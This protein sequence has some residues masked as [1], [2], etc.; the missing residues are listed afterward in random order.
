MSGLANSTNRISLGA[1][2]AFATGSDSLGR[3]VA[4][5]VPQLVYW[6]LLLVSKTGPELLSP[7]RAGT[8]VLFSLATRAAQN[9]TVWAETNLAAPNWTAQTSFAG[10]GATSQVTLPFPAAAARASYRVSQP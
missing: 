3:Y 2:L 8:N 5:T 9:Y 10:N 7:H 1:P 6:D 4:V